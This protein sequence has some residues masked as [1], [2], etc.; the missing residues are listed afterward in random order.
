MAVLD[1]SLNRFKGLIRDIDPE[2][3]FHVSF[4]EG[5]RLSI[6]ESDGKNGCHYNIKINRKKIRSQGQ[7]DQTIDGIRSSLLS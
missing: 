2:A 5:S 6:Y 1:K 7:F 3:E 4:H